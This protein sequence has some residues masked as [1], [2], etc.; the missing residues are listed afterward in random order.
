MEVICLSGASCTGKTH[1]TDQL[2]N[3]IKN[4]LVLS[5]KSPTYKI[6]K[7]F[8]EKCPNN[9]NSVTMRQFYLIH[10]TTEYFFNTIANRIKNIGKGI[11]VFD[12][13]PID[14]IAYLLT[15]LEYKKGIISDESLFNRLIEL[16]EIKYSDRLTSGFTNIF[17][18]YGSNIV[19][20]FII[21]APFEDDNPD[22]NEFLE[23]TCKKKDSRVRFLNEFG[24]QYDPK[25]NI[26]QFKKFTEVYY[27]FIIDI[28][29]L[30]RTNLSKR[31]PD[32]FLKE[33]FRVASF[34]NTKDFPFEWQNKVLE[35][36]R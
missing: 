35:L 14:Y 26:Q 23:K 22:Y 2:K 31:Y 8:E 10:R 34:T 3:K 33:K 21:L 9:K 18:L 29:N 15:F 32:D 24:I 12:R 16:L 28:V 30:V 36:V 7:E 6:I 19:F 4:K 17:D 1:F 11:F 13:T 20:N 27:K 25:L 5:F